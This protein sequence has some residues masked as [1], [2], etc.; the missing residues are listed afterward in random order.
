[1]SALTNKLAGYSNLYFIHYIDGN[2]S[3][4]VQFDAFNTEESKVICRPGFR[5][6]LSFSSKR[7]A[8]DSLLFIRIFVT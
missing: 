5:L 4:R 1:M 6:S 2:K 8:M 3:V 7:L